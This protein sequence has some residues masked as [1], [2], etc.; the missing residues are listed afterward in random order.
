MRSDRLVEEIKSRIDIVDLIA[1]H[2]VLRKAGQNYKGLCPFH[3]EKTPSFTVSPSKQ[4]FHCFG[5]SKGG[6]AVSFVMNHESL[7]FPEA[8]SYL[9][10]KAGIR[11][12]EFRTG[13]PVQRGLKEKLLSLHAAALD[14]FRLNLAASK[15]ARTYLSERGVDAES[16]EIFGLGY[17]LPARDSLFLH[18]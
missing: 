7:S 15:R 1:E 5:C 17:S 11:V 6:D 12:E 3:D 8:L 9:A 2:V 13:D 14:Y 16:T 10:Q 4:I 18:L